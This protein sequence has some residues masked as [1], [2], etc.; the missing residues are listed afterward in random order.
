MPAELLLRRLQRRAAHIAG[1]KHPPSFGTGCS[2]DPHSTPP[3]KGAQP[4]DVLQRRAYGPLQWG[5]FLL[6][7]PASTS[8]ISAPRPPTERARRRYS[9]IT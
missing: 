2:I 1:R 7:T 3:L 5:V 9:L 6:R 4:L 8:R